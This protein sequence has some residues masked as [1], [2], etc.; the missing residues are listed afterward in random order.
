M[1]DICEKR[2]DCFALLDGLDESN[3]DTALAKMVGVTGSGEAGRWASIFDG[4]SIFFDSTYTKLNVEA[5][6]SIEMAGIISNNRRGGLYW[7]PPAGKDF[8]TIPGSFA[9]RQKFVRKYNF[10]EDPNS[11]IARLYDSNI[12]PTRVTEAGMIIYGQKTLLRRSS[13]LNRL[14]VI[15]LV[16]GMH[17]KFVKFLDTKVFNLNTAALRAGIVST[18][19]SEVERIKNAN[20][21]GLF[22][23]TVIC[24]E[25]NNPPEVIDQNKMFVDLII[26]PTRAA[27]FITLRTTVQR[28]GDELTITNVEIIGG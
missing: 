26:Q 4:R 19:N 7:I 12:N 18:L 2:K 10:A 28:T 22:T 8:G 11:D 5:V 23:G 20:P 1:L 13:A 3:I 21:S 17:K 25:T 14:N 24:D 15:M 9:T 6:K 27:E 16:A